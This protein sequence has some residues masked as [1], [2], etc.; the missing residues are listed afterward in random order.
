MLAK[1]KYT[2][3]Q[4][5]FNS[6]VGANLRFARLRKKLTQDQAG[7]FI[8]V[9]FQQIQKYEN[10]HNACSFYRISQ[11]SKLYDVPLTDLMHTDYIARQLA[12]DETAA[13]NNGVVKPKDYQNALADRMHVKEQL[14]SDDY[15]DALKG[16][17]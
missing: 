2:P 13:L 6:I 10:A 17:L 14:D 8:G 12:Y 11:F 4:I 3:E 9:T 15:I 7:K 1:T 5:Q 16:R